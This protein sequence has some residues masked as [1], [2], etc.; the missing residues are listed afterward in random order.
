M[1]LYNIKKLLYITFIFLLMPFSISAQ[2]KYEQHVERYQSAWQKLIPR[3][4]K[5]QF[6]GSM[7]L[8]S[9]GIGWD[10]GKKHQWETDVML[11]FVPHYTSKA[12]ATFTLKQNYMPWKVNLGNNFSMEPLTC[13]LYVNTVLSGDFWVREPDRYPHG[14][15]NFSTKIRS[16]IFA[17]QRFTYNFDMDKVHIAKAVT[18]F[19]E[20]GTSDLYIVSA[21]GNSYLK[22]KDYLHLSLG[23]KLQIL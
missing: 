23:L 13:G 6:A 15:Y 20:I 7:G 16:N 18:F 17:G 4:T 12:K 1:K 22:P 3:Y 19:Y 5:L 21:F 2:S 9:A 8:L 14:Y 11:G 10:Y